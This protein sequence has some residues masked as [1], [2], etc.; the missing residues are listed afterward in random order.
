MK[1]SLT[2]IFVVLALAAAVATIQ[3]V[4]ARNGAEAPCCAPLLPADSGEASPPAQ[5]SAL[6]RLVDLGADKCIP[7]KMMAPILA[8]MKTTFAGRLEVEF[9]DVWKTPEAGRRYGVRLIPTQIFFAPDGTEL[10]RHE[11]FL[12]REDIVAKWKELG[13]RLEEG[14]AP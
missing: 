11:G 9:V 13:V 3:F 2:G 1:R 4:R 5:T 7:C 12:S 10:A 8:E 6:P 14:S